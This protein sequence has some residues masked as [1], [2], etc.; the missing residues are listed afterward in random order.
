MSLTQAKKTCLPPARVGKTG[1]VLR[2]ASARLSLQTAVRGEAVNAP[3]L[4]S[5][6]GRFEFTGTD[7]GVFHGQ[8]AYLRV[9][10]Q[11]VHV[12]LGGAIDGPGGLAGLHKALV[13]QGLTVVKGGETSLTVRIGVQR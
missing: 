2:P 4:V 6:G 13:A 3:E 1:L 11:G 8:L 5:N 12:R 7:G 10:G 9:T